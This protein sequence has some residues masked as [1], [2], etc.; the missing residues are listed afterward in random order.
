MP[1]TMTLRVKNVSLLAMLE[2]T[3]SSQKTWTPIPTLVKSCDLFAHQFPLQVN[4]RLDGH[5]GP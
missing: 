4:M 2:R 5:A 3:N 1:E